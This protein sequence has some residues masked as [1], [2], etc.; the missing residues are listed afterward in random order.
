[1]APSDPSP[2]PPEGA[3]PLGA[4]AYLAAEGFVDELVAELSHDGGEIRAVHDRLV[5]AEGPARPAA[6]A[7]TVWLDPWT[8]PV[9]SI[10]EAS[11]ALRGVQRN[12]SLY[13]VACHRRAALVADKLPR[14]SARPLAFPAPAPSGH[15]GAFTLLDE[16]TLLA[17]PRTT[18]PFV[19]GE[20]QFVEDKLGP[21]NRAYRKLWE[22]FTVLGEYPQPGERVVDLGASPGGWTW[23]S[24][25]LGADVIGVDKAPL[26][27]AI[28]A[29]P[30]RKSVV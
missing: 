11:R 3:T 25:E 17:A 14:I 26:D 10:G 1:M 16:H 30:D 27:P 7:A 23:V 8:L 15:L 18:S 12:W 19:H 4:T 21:P 2:A 5:L 28:A 22:A 6:W 9:A 29:R 20:V 24:A 13:S